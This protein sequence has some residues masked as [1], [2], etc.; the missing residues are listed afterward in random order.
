MD[1]VGG[2]GGG[3]GLDKPVNLPLALCFCS[4]KHPPVYDPLVIT[5]AS[6]P[7]GWVQLQNS[8]EILVGH[9]SLLHRLIRAAIVGFGPGLHLPSLHLSEGSGTILSFQIF[10]VSFQGWGLLPGS[11]EPSAFLSLSHRHP[12]GKHELTRWP[13]GEVWLK[14]YCH[15]QVCQTLKNGF[16]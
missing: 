2:L 15:S 5:V 3:S 4:L 1:D 7:Q 16:Y 6:R 11:L 14:H 13:G 9:R 12:C 8:A 10:A